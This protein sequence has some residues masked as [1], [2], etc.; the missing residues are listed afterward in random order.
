MP[1]FRPHQKKKNGGAVSWKSRRQDS[2]S[3][4]TSEA[5]FVAASQC[6]Q[7]VLYLR[8]VPRDFHQ[9]QQS[10]TLVYED[11]LACIAMS[12]KAVRRK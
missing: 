8:E 10:H 7:E 2:V 1:V 11:N 4:S 6:A 12:E 3:L 5:E 9:T